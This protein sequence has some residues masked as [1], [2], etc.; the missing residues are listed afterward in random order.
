MLPQLLAESRGT[1]TANLAQTTL[2]PAGMLAASAL[3][4]KPAALAEL[5]VTVKETHDANVYGA[6]LNP[7]L[8]G[9]PE[10]ADVAS[11]VTIVSPKAVLNL[12]SVLGLGDGPALHVL[13]HH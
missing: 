10:I 8:A 3:A 2:P 13:G 12:R 5:A 9:L 4:A 11:W 1:Q 6:E 7:T